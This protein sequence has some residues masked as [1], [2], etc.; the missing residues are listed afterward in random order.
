MD[1]RTSVGA[2]GR[3]RALALALAVALAA[4]LV[5]ALHP[6][7]GHAA[8]ATYVVKVDAKPPKG[9]M[10]DFMRFFPSSLAV[11]A[12]DT[13]RFEWNGV[14]GPHTATLVDARRAHH[15]RTVHQGK[16][17]DYRLFVKDTTLGGDDHNLVIN[18]QV[19]APCGPPPSPTCSF[20]GTGVVNSGIQFS[21]PSDQPTFTVNVD[22][23]TPPGEYS[24]LCLLHPGMEM[25]LYV[26]PP[27]TKIQSPSQVLADAQAEIGHAKHV[28]GPA[29]DAKVQRVRRQR[30]DDGHVHWWIHAG[31]VVGGV[32]ADEFLDRT[33]R[34][35]KGDRITVVGSM[36]IHNLTFPF[37][38]S[39]ARPFIATVCEQTGKDKPAQSPADCA[40]PMDFRIDLNPNVTKATDSHVLSRHEV[41]NSGILIKPNPADGV[42]YPFRDHFTYKAKHVG[43]FHGLCNVHGP[44]MDIHIRVLP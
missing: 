23:A 14:E 2:P 17:G 26:M 6:V 22:P 41:R 44:M 21:N 1:P 28:D 31:A 29:A 16:G 8:G 27:G 42:S 11:H 4:S 25:H 12:G 37:T 35:H 7:A 5:V 33:L 10:W 38:R 32:S 30:M 18:P 9:E 36:E 13:I 19:A 39:A 24:V 34:V 3:R 15:W 20:D 43:R 40:S